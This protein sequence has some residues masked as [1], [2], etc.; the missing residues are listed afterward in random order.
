MIPIKAAISIYHAI[1]D[2][3]AVSQVVIMIASTICDLN[4][5]LMYLQRPLDLLFDYE[6]QLSDQQLVRHIKMY[7]GT[8]LR[9]TQGIQPE[10]H[11]IHVSSFAVKTEYVDIC[12]R[13]AKF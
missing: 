12:F 4:Y 9:D 5:K 7:R 6:S 2:V 1:M 8:T 3:D 11:P 10:Y 13:L